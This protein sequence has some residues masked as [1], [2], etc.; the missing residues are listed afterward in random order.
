MVPLA[1]Y[2]RLVAA[3]RRFCRRRGS[4]RTL[5]QLRSNGRG[6]LQLGPRLHELLAKEVSL[7]LRAPELLP[8]ILQGLVMLLGRFANLLTSPIDFGQPPPLRRG[9]QFLQLRALALVGD[10]CPIELVP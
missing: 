8:Q 10:R 6:G 1:S 7:A 4:L 5:L 9:V 2:E 3:P